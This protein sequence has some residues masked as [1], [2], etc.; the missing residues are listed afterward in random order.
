MCSAVKTC[1]K[2][3]NKFKVKKKNKTLRKKKMLKLQQVKM[4]FNRKKSLHV[5]SI[6]I[7]DNFCEEN[8]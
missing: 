6:S 4:D 2:T 5:P 7:F 1:R 8:Q 3:Y